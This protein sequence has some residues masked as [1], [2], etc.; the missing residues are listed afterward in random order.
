MHSLSTIYYRTPSVFGA[1]ILGSKIQSCLARYVG[2]ATQS[3]ALISLSRAVGGR[4]TRVRTAPRV[5]IGYISPDLGAGAGILK[6]LFSTI[7][8]ESADPSFAKISSD[9]PEF[10][11]VLYVIPVGRYYSAF[12]QTDTISDFPWEHGDR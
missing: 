3:H 11:G 9:D 7:A 2:F 8:T 6:D 1:S 4:F 5:F 10:H 12:G